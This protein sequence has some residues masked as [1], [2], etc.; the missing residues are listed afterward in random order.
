[1]SD[2]FDHIQ[3]SPDDAAI[4]RRGAAVVKKRVIAEYVDKVRE[5]NL[6]LL[7]SLVLRDRRLDVLAEHVLGYKPKPFHRAMMQH[8]EDHPE[9]LYL[10]FRGAAKT[11]YLNITRCIAEILWDPDIRILIVSNSKDQAKLFLREIKKQF[12][13]NELLRAAFGDY[14]S[15]VDKWGEDEIVVRKR[16]RVYRDA[17]IK[18]AGSET[19]LPGT[20]VDVIIADDIV[21]EEAART[22]GQREKLKTFFYKTLGP[23][24]EPHRA[25]DSD[26]PGKMWVIGNPYH[27]LDLYAHLQSHE[28]ADATLVQP[29]LDDNDESVWPE[30]FPTDLIRRRRHAMGHLIFALQYM[31]EAHA[32]RGE[33]MEPSWFRYYTVAPENLIVWQGVDLAISQKTTADFFAHVTIGVQKITRDV[34]LLDFYERRLTFKRQVDFIAEQ[35]KR[36]DPLRVVIEANAYQ[37]ALRQYLRVDYPDVRAVPRF[38]NV[39]KVTRAK[40]FSAILE[41]GR[42]HVRNDHGPMIDHLCSLPSSGRFDLFDALDL[43]VGQGMRGVRK[44]RAKVGLI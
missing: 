15:T 34:Y 41:S 13:A 33:I 35:F 6:D 40:K 31:C 10:A 24:L 11:T 28:M 39:D 42:F 20:H 16:T 23:I 7:R 32:Q 37:D 22:E 5:R 29:I 26:I 19:A 9:A 36:W 4:M 38:T 2:E 27:H 8:Q 17:T 21:L 1:M 25:H 30:R 44:R 14:V 3:V 18:C 12:E 43:A